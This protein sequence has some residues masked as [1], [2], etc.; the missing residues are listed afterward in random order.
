MTAS[1]QDIACSLWPER[2]SKAK[3][4][5]LTHGHNT[6]SDAIRLTM[7]QHA[8]ISPATGRVL[9]LDQVHPST[10]GKADIAQEE[11]AAA[12]YFIKDLKGTPTRCCTAQA[13]ARDW[14]GIESPPTLA[15]SFTANVD[16]TPNAI[17][18]H[19]TISSLAFLVLGGEDFQTVG[20]N[21][22]GHDTGH[23]SKLVS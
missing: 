12:K 22:L 8:L 4:A 19:V 1:L 2:E 5:I 21:T 3:E 20:S 11:E 6:G 7:R 23:S 9:S 17:N 13:S 14:L 15:N 16:Y 18:L 10:S